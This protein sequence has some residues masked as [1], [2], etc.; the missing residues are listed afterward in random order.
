M[1]MLKS[2]KVLLGSHPVACVIR[3]ISEGGVCLEMSS[4][5]GVPGVFDLVIGEKPPRTCKVMWLNGAR[6]GAQFQDTADP[7]HPVAA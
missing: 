5:F 2:G 3:N 6:I 1:R 4:T 7:Y